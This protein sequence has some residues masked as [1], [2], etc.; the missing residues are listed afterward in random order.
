MSILESKL[1]IK[2]LVLKNR[3]VIPPMFTKK[4]DDSGRVTKS[5]I[6]YYKEK[7]SGGYF[8]LVIVEHTSVSSAGK[9]HINQISN[10][11][12]EDV[13]G[14]SKIAEAIHQNG[15]A[16]VLQ[17]NHAGARGFDSANNAAPSPIHMDSS[18]GPLNADSGMTVDSITELVKQFTEAAVRT[19]KAGYDGVEIHSAHGYLLNQFYS[20]IT[21]KRTDAYGGNV[22]GRIKLLLDIISSVRSAVGK[23]YPIFVRLGACDFADGGNTVKDAVEAAIKIEKAGAD[24]IDVSGGMVGFIL[25]GRENEQGY[26]SEESMAIK[27]AVSVPVILT[28]GVKKISSA[29]KLLKDGKAD[30][31]GIG[32]AIYQDS[33]W[34]EN[35]FL[36]FISQ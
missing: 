18:L 25:K 30:L 2:N 34:A 9:A 11:S 35:E 4:A 6:N 3:L 28:G 8:S 33:K 36:E 16:A 19:K 10:S 5:H 26:F 24:V 29:E 31:I 32:R 12:D 13:E 21:N 7:T 27:Q 17:L 15:S 22:T 1:K 14:L 23:D 20:P